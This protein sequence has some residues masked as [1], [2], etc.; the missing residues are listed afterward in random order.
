MEDGVGALVTGAETIKILDLLTNDKARLIIL[1]TL[2]NYE[3]NKI[4]YSCNNW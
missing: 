3:A 2:K 1:L 4:C